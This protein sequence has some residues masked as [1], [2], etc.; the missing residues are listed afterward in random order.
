MTYALGVQVSMLSA[1]D[2][3]C[4]IVPQVHAPVPADWGPHCNKLSSL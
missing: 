4:K 3:V 2:A 1:R